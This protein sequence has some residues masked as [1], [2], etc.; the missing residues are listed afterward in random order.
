MLTWA[1]PIPV[2]TKH[3]MN[4]SEA[5]VGAIKTNSHSRHLV[6]NDSHSKRVVLHAVTSKAAV[7]TNQKKCHPTFNEHKMETT[8][9]PT[10]GTPKK[11]RTEKRYLPAPKITTN[12]L[13]FV[14][15]RAKKSSLQ[16]PPHSRP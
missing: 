3:R 13:G 7:R 10:K 1:F 6:F 2:K 14:S 16:L 9:N 11:Q 15:Y 5:N 4:V 12:L 8:H